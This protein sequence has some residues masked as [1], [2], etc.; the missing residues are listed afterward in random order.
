VPIEIE[1]KMR[2]ADR[3]AIESRLAET[4]AT[5]VADLH[6][7]NTF[8]DTPGNT[9]KSADRGLRV[10]VERQA[11]DDKPTVI[12][13]HKGPRAHGK[14]KS[15]SETELQVADEQA[16]VALL[17]ALG[18]NPVLSFEKRRTRYALDDCLVELDRLPHLGEFIEIEGPGDDAVMAV[19]ER[20]GL[21]DEP[22]VR[23]SYIA[24]LS[25]FLS[26]QNIRTTHVGFESTVTV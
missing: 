5:F 19:R 9:L 15:R 12:I 18:Y 13:T 23:A 24:M 22:L 25:D 1:A 14:L 7:V 21:A 3:A 8:F 4:G 26:Q 2:L 16:A 10:R 6:E 17:G 11:G 20:L